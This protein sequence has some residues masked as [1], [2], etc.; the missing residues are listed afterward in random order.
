LL[1]EDDVFFRDT[2][3]PV[4][5]SAGYAVTVADSAM[6]M[7]DLL[8]SRKD[9]D[10]VMIDAEMT[11]PN[12]RNLAK[13]LRQTLADARLPIFLLHEMPSHAVLGLPADD[14]MTRNLSK[15]DRQTLLSTLASILA[16]QEMDHTSK[17]MA[18]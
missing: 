15:L 4:L 16:A 2:L 11:T 5:A 3:R 9:F 14:H 6:Q 10:A 8:E 1:V 17:D 18:A 7:Q 13:H 12:G